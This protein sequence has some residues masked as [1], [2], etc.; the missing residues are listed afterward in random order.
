MTFW[1]PGYPPHLISSDFFQMISITVLAVRLKQALDKTRRTAA[2]SPTFDNSQEIGNLQAIHGGEKLMH[3]LV[4][5]VYCT[6][7]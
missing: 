5:M 6:Y 3:T 2:T 7:I 1:G 4:V